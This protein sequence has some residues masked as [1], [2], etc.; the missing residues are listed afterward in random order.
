MSR[1]RSWSPRLSPIRGRIPGLAPLL[2]IAVCAAPASSGTQDEAANEV[3]PEARDRAIVKAFEFLDREVWSLNEHGSPQKQYA[4]A[5]TA[6]ASLLA[7]DRVGGAKR[8]PSRS[9]AM[10]RLRSALER[11]VETVAR[12]YEKDDDRRKAVVDGR[13]VSRGRISGEI[14]RREGPNAV[15]DHHRDALG[16]RDDG[17][18]LRKE[19]SST[20]EIG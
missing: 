16:D 4:V 9:K 14:V 20:W 12:E 13:G 15:K 11:Y 1:R 19:P 3:S 17:S 7:R 18:Q 10:D 6:W 5:M 8:L 2:L